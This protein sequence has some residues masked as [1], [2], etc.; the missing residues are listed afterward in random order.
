MIKTYFRNNNKM[1]KKL[2]LG[3]LSL[4]LIFTS[5]Q[6]QDDPKKSFKQA[7]RALG[8]YNLDPSA[9]ESKLYEAIDKINHAVSDEEI[10]SKPKTWITKGQIFNAIAAKETNTKYI[11]ETYEI[12]YPSAAIEAADAFLKVWEVSDKKGDH[13]EALTG[14]VDTEN[15]LTNFAYT[16][17]KD[18]AYAAANE[19]FEKG[20]IVSEKL[21]SN[22]SESKMSDPG[23]KQDYMYYSGLCQY[24]M[25]DF[26]KAKATF[27]SIY[28]EGN[29]N[30]VVYDMLYRVE[31]TDNMEAAAKYLE[32]GRKKFPDDH[33][34][35]EMGV[36]SYVGIPLHD[37][38]G[39]A[40]GLLV[41]MDDK[42]MR[43][44]AFAES[45][46]KVFGMRASAEL[47]RKE[48]EEILKL[49]E[50]AIGE[51]TNGIINLF[52]ECIKH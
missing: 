7:S 43:G 32:E 47:E 33:L 37:S 42:P 35:E 15:H 44:E 25:E 20:K 40:M 6:A 22:G 21:L 23:N 8:S 17:L 19:N 18:K 36:D 24:Y 52:T 51:A 27:V 38:S 9:N 11:D 2:I 4:T 10:A 28:E 16:G 12:K 14:L 13:K 49:R 34:L 29:A 26:A 41:A 1:M 39:R 46:L 48:A 50:R 30:A 5:L 45:I 31:S 3:F